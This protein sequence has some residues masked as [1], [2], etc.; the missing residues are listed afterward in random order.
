M[1]FSI[2]W[3]YLRNEAAA[4]ELAQEVFLELF[5]SIRS[6]ESPAHL[7]FWLRRVM[8]HRCIDY[9]RRRR[10]RPSLALQQIPEPAESPAMADPFLAARLRKLTASLPQKPRMVLI[11]RFQEDLDPAEIAG[12]LDMPVNTVKSHLQRSLAVLREKFKKSRL[13]RAELHS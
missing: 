12:V 13:E 6:I 11:L 1:V 8:T 9:S 10:N 2:G 4:E 5:Q 7:T 3:N